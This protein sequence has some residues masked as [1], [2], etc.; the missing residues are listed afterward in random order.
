MKKTTK[1]KT[2]VKKP[3]VLTTAA[4]FKELQEWYLEWLMGNDIDI[5]NFKRK[6]SRLELGYP[7]FEKPW[8]SGEF[9]IEPQ[10]DGKIKVTVREYNENTN[11]VRNAIPPK[12]YTSVADWMADCDFYPSEKKDRYKPKRDN[13]RY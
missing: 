13:F 8:R 1:K 2:V 4:I 9:C 3:K 12:T 10:K 7:T 5:V 11:K 6:P